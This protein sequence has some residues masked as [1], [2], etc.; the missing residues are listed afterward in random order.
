[1]N[2]GIEGHSAY[3][4]TFPVRIGFPGR[5]IALC[6]LFALLLIA[7]LIGPSALIIAQKAASAPSD[8]QMSGTQVAV[9]GD[10][11]EG[12]SKKSSGEPKRPKGALY[13]KGKI[14]IIYAFDTPS[15]EDA[16]P[17]T[18]HTELSGTVIFATEAE[19]EDDILPPQ[20]LQRPPPI[21]FM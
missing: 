15:G 5:L 10:K 1:M 19:P 8:I 13:T 20:L 14:G 11:R 3:S 9:G 2:L 18:A 4:V 12:D 16:T 17:R 21:S 6:Y 7:T